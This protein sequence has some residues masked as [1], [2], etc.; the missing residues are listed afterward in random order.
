MSNWQVLQV[1]GN[2][3][4][5]HAA[6]TRE[7]ALVLVFLRLEEGIAYSILRE[8]ACSPKRTSLRAAIYI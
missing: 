4:F 7:A 8:G 1:S 3:S 6:D 2:G 5:D